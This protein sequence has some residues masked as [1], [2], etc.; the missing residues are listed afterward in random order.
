VAAAIGYV[1]AG[2]IS[3]SSEA[4]W[5]RERRIDRAM[6]RHVEELMTTPVIAVPPSATLREFVGCYVVPQRHKSFP[7]AEGDQLVG[8]VA[9]SDVS[10]LPRDRWD[11]VL[12]RDVM[13]TDVATTVASAVVGQV[14]EVMEE[15]DYDRVPVLDDANRLTGIISTRDVVALGELQEGWRRRP[16]KAS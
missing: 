10:P 2:R 12:V 11:E 13:A 4:R 1:I 7:V 5:R 6:H 3:V 8:M 14:V 9:L 15:N 16:Y